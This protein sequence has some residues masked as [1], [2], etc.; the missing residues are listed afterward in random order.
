MRK[1][2]TKEFLIE[3][4]IKNSLSYVPFKR[5]YADIKIKLLMQ[6]KLKKLGVL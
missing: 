5:Q 4:Y 6:D 2:I 3:E 1:Q